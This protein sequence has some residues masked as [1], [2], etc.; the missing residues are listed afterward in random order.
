MTDKQVRDLIFQTVLAAAIQ[1]IEAAIPFFRLPVIS[2]IFSFVVTKIATV[3]YEELSKS[4]AF[5]LIDMRVGR[6]RDEYKA[7]V[8]E[9][10]QVA[11]SPTATPEERN[12]A[13]EKFKRTLGA[14]IRLKP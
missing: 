6:E 7:A 13:E 12:A 4:V 3:L 8:A 5:A 11:A 10:K 2:T 14:L 1:A 9:I